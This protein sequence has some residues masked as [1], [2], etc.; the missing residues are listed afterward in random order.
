MPEVGAPTD[1]LNSWRTTGNAE[2]VNF[3]PTKMTIE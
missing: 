1:S 3:I 2:T